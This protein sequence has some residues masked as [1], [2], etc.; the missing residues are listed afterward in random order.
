M[1]RWSWIEQVLSPLA[2]AVFTAAWVNL[3]GVWAARA[4][5]NPDRPAVPLIYLVALLLAGSV[6]TSWIIERAGSPD[7]RPLWV[8]VWGGM[9]DVAQALHDDPGIKRRIRVYCTGAWN[10]RND[11]AARNYVFEHHRD[12]WWIEADTTF[13]GMYIGGVQDGEWDNRAFLTGHVA[14]HGALGDLLVRKKADLKMGDTPTL[15]YLLR[16][17]P[18]DPSSPHWGG[19]FLRTDHGPSYWTDDPAP[20]LR[21]RDL[22]GAKTVSRWRVDYL[23]DWQRRMDRLLPE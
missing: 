13:R 12:L 9:A 3:Y 11:P 14:G 19:A 4:T 20:E 18:D 2:A 23:R 21:E 22:S 7:P 5:A 17:N 15:L 16:G 10:T 6:T 1:K 8:L